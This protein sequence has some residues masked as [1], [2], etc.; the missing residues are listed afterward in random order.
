MDLFEC[1]KLVCICLLVF[2]FK[3]PRNKT[4]FIVHYNYI[5][6]K[7]IHFFTNSHSG[8]LFE[9]SS[10]ICLAN[11]EVVNSGKTSDFSFLVSLNSAS[12]ISINFYE[13]G[14][15]SDFFF[16]IPSTLNNSQTTV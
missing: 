2:I 7:D 14:K 8:L 12:L 9:C 16:F 4:N 6:I 3:E 10:M 13:V 15:K 5:N 11:S 1:V